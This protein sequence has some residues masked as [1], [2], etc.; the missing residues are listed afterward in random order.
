MLEYFQ[1]VMR[2]PHCMNPLVQAYVWK[3]DFCGK[4]GG[5]L[6]IQYTEGYY[7]NPPAFVQIFGWSGVGKTVYLYAL[8]LMLVKMANVWPRYSY[9]A[10]ND[11]TQLKVS[12]INDLLTKGQLPEITKPGSEELYLIALRNIEHWGGRILVSRDCAGE[13]FQ[14]MNV[15]IEETPYL[16]QA[17]TT[18]MMIGPQGDISNAYGRSCDQLLNNYINTLV[19]AGVNFHRKRRRLVVVLSKADQIR[20]LPANL[21]SYL[22]SDPLWAAANTRGNRQIYT[23]PEMEKYLMKMQQISDEIRDWFAEDA[24]GKNFLRLA[25]QRRLDLRFSLV[26]STGET[27]PNGQTPPTKL[28]PRRVLDPLLWALELNKANRGF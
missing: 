10:L 26:S 13:V 4:C 22:I 28:E 20:D 6:P 21:R 15:N 18:F 19:A 9:A 25:E 12:A 8:T 7:Q 23:A 3:P 14:N 1:R 5:E 16:K 11:E 17:S 24:V 2:C 27:V